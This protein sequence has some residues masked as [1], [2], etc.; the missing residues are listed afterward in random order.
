[1]GYDVWEMFDIEV[2]CSVCGAQAALSV[3][4]GTQGSA[5]AAARAGLAAEHGWSFTPDRHLCPNCLG[6]AP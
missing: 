5:D 1:M 4:A 6:P 2:A 3:L